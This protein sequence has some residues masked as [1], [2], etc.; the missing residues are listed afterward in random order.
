M[1]IEIDSCILSSFIDRK[2]KLEHRQVR[3]AQRNHVFV[4]FFFSL[5][6]N[7][8]SPRNNTDH[9]KCYMQSEEISDKRKEC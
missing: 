9:G 5:E 2:K 8:T 7:T 6:N 4:K 3:L 1:M